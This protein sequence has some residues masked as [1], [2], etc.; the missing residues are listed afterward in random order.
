MPAEQI[1]ITRWS[2][3]SPYAFKSPPNVSRR[4]PASTSGSNLQAS[5]ERRAEVVALFHL[6]EGDPKL[7]ELI[8]FNRVPRDA[9]VVHK[10][11]EVV[12]LPHVRPLF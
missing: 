8:P 1:Y 12:D 3:C 11:V 2:R 9:E 10:V 4:E 5:D 6:R 7:E